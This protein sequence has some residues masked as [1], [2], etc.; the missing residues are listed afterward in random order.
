[1]PVYFDSPAAK[2]HWV[3]AHHS[4][5]RY[6]LARGIFL[7]LLWL[8]NSDFRAGMVVSTGLLVA[9]AMLLI[10]AARRLRSSSIRGSE[11]SWSRPSR[12]PHCYRLRNRAGCGWRCRIAPRHTS[13][14]CG[15]ASEPPN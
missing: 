10:V 4:E 5:H 13:W 11:P 15:S 2:W 6:P 9:S 12:L 3:F 14:P 1:M 8:T 7:G